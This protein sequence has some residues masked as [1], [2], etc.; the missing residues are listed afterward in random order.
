M[1]TLAC[2]MLGWMLFALVF[3]VV[4]L[5]ANTA[6]AEMRITND[7]GGQIGEYVRS[8][9][10]VRKSGETVVIDGDCLSACTLVLTFVPKKRVCVTKKA[11]LGF[12]AAWNP[13]EKGRPVISVEGSVL[14]WALYPKKIRTWIRDRGGLSA[15]MIYLKGAELAGMVN[16]CLPAPQRAISA[17]ASSLPR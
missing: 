4:L 8:F 5:Y 3:A 10:L 6:Q 17:Q 7:R 9:N 1:R 15:K 2:K 14:L 12:H 13:D 11:R 16:R